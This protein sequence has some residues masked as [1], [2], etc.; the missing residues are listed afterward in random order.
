M[1]QP[2]PPDE[3]TQL[4][5]PGMVGQPVCSFNVY[6]ESADGL[7]Q[8][9][10]TNWARPHTPRLEY[11]P[12]YNVNWAGTDLGILIFTNSP[13]LWHTLYFFPLCLVIISSPG[14]HMAQPS[15]HHSS[16]SL[17]FTN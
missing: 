1:G 10:T 15:W 5:L 17:S 9:I 12:G 11:D 13:F 2:S 16:S 8:G 6:Y 4:N 14:K 7:A 3:L